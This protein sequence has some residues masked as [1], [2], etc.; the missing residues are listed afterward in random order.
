LENPATV[1]MG[2][3]IGTMDGEK[4]LENSTFIRA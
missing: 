2:G 1:S 3:A 4:R